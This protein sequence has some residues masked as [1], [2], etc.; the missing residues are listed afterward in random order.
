MTREHA[1]KLY[2]LERPDPENGED[3]ELSLYEAVVEIPRRVSLC[4]RY[5]WGGASFRLVAGPMKCIQAHSV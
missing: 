3:G 2:K 4:I 1:L 5:I